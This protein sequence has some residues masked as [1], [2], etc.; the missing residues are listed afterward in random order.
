[1]K[2]LFFLTDAV[3]GS[4]LIGIGVTGFLCG[5]VF[6]AG[7]GRIRRRKQEKTV[8]LAIQEGTVPMDSLLG[9]SLDQD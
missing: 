8:C 4:F 9:G 1:M 5:L 2:E 6:C 7:I 3:N